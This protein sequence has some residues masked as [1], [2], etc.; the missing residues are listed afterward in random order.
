M[1]TLN[2]KTDSQKYNK[3]E[4]M[5][6]FIRKIESIIEVAVLALAFYLMW[7]KYYRKQTFPY[8]GNGK[9]LLIAVYVIISVIILFLCDS[10]KFGHRKL[11]EILP[12]Q[13]VSIFLINFITYFQ[14]C[15]ISNKMLKPLPMLILSGL[16][17]LLA[18]L[19]SYVYTAIYHQI[20]VPKNIVMIYGNEK[21]IDLKFKMDVRSDKYNITRILSYE[22]DPD[23]IRGEI[24]KHDAVIIND[25]PAEIRND[26]MKYCYQQ[27]IRTY[28]VPKISDIIT[29]GA[30]EISL[31]DTPLL[32]INSTGLTPAQKFAKR[33]LDLL[34]CCIA[35]IPAGPIMLIIALCIKL[36]DHGPVFYRQK[37]VTEGGRVFEILKFRSMIVDAE[38]NGYSMDLRAT[39]KDP[40][41]TRTGNVIRACRLDELPQLF[42]IIKGD[43][44]IVGP[45]PERVENVE[46]YSAEIPEFEYRTKVKGGL[47]GYAQIYGKYNTSAYDKLRLDLMYIEN[48]SFFLD[49]KLIFMT[50]QILLKKESTEGF[51][52]AEEIEQ[53]RN[54]LLAK[55]AAALDLR[56][57]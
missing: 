42:N 6:D 39:D 24:V 55:S 28:L 17:F 49:I 41:I 34:L 53:K 38:K 32:S 56:N 12:A 7:G 23:V 45:R 37:R 4:E 11:S 21:A 48:Y 16:D 18:G 19:F 26:I 20:Y 44:S 57:E 2:E 29:R 27:S 1:S 8:Y 54:E 9:F 25:V 40:R 30:E 43:M 36:E 46:A 14:L 33:A 51:D 52:K 3:K 13:W 47:T 10:F 50:I 22:E 15:L 31:F 35:M 5:K